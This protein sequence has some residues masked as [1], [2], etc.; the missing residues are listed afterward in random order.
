MVNAC[1]LQDARSI[2]ADLSQRSGGWSIR[3]SQ[4]AEKVNGAD[5]FQFFVSV[6]IRRVEVQRKMQSRRV[7]RAAWQRWENG[8]FRVI[9]LPDSGQ[10]ES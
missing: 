7:R 9:R 6:L 4:A 5:A 10:S 3:M 1:K 8:C 2:M